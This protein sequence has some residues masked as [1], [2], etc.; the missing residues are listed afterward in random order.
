MLY[1][2]TVDIWKQTSTVKTTA[3]SLLHFFPPTDHM[4]HSNMILDR[5]L[6]INN[7]S[8]KI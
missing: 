4:N 1:I 8:Y 7:V 6:C 2:M 3:V 5:N